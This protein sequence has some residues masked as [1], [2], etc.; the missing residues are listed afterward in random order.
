MLTDLPNLSAIALFLTTLLL[1]YRDIAQPSWDDRFS[2]AAAVISVFSILVYTLVERGGLI[3]I[4]IVALPFTLMVALFCLGLPPWRKVSKQALR[5]RLVSI[6]ICVV[7][8]VFT[9]SR[10]QPQITPFLQKEGDFANDPAFGLL[11]LPMA[12]IFLAWRLLHNPGKRDKTAF[13][14]AQLGCLSVMVSGPLLFLL[15]LCGIAAVACMAGPPHLDKGAAGLVFRLACVF[16]VAIAG[17]SWTMAQVPPGG[18]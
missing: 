7:A 9:L 3:P 8:G 10:G 1:F 2:L 12:G 17:W 15:P 5:H 11:L 13:A 16:G 6:V 4:G 18:F 14:A